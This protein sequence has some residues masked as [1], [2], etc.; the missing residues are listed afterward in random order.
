MPTKDAAV[1]EAILEVIG[2]S[3]IGRKKIIV[4]VQKKYPYLGASKIRRVYQKEGFSLY[5]RFRK[6]RFNNP[7]DNTVRFVP[8]VSV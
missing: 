3:R 8:P 4:K 2:T 7:V 6:K 1:K 5:K